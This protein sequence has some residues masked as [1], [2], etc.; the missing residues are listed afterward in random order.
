[1]KPALHNISHFVF[2]LLIAILFES[3]SENPKS[4]EDSSVQIFDEEIQVDSI[5]HFEN[6]QTITRISS[7]SIIL[8]T[9][10]LKVEELLAFDADIE[11]P[12]PNDF[13]EPEQWN[14]MY[15]DPHVFIGQFPYLVFGS[16]QICIAASYVG[17]CDSCIDTTGLTQLQFD[18]FDGPYVMPDEPGYE[19]WKNETPISNSFGELKVVSRPALC[20]D[21]GCSSSNLRTQSGKIKTL[22][23]W[24]NIIYFEADVDKDTNNEGYLIVYGACGVW[25]NIYRISKSN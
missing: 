16:T 5:K 4:I 24:Q 12:F 3:C 6:F 20:Y 18:F 8:N 2:L 15:A 17:I 7:D 21:T 11:E 19:T 9:S 14:M 13:F 1:M 22:Q 10:E 25:M 23:H